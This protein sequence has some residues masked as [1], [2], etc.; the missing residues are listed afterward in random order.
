MKKYVTYYPEVELKNLGLFAPMVVYNPGV[1]RNMFNDP[2]SPSAS[3]ML[4]I[5]PQ[6]WDAPNRWFE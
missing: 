3:V 2:I 5:G 6:D 1:R 4:I